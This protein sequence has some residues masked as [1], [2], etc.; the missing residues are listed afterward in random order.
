[1]KFEVL[2]N[3][4]IEQIHRASIK[5]LETIGVRVS[6]KE[7]LERLQQNGAEVD[8]AA[9]SAKIPERLVMD[10]LEK[11]GKDFCV[12]GRN[13]D[14]QARFGFG[15]RNYNSIAG[16][17]HWVDDFCMERRPASLADVVTATR[18]GDALEHIN[19]VGAMSDPYELPVSYRCVEVAAEQ[20][21]NTTKPITFW[22]HDRKSAKYVLEVFAAV[23]GSEEEAMEKP[24]AYPLLEPIRG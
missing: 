9:E 2:T 24:F 4:Q 5:I 19:V 13:P 15:E 8:K 14:N 6:H 12:F 7:V 17:A 23:A 21:R 18:F 16:E 20:L 10:S 11:A 22:F 1:M 3:K